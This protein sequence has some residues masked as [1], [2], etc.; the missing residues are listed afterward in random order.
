METDG[1]AVGVVDWI[2]EQVIRIDYHR[3][4]HYQKWFPERAICQTPVSQGNAY[5]EEDV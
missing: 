1:A 2:R 4:H 3:R 5:G